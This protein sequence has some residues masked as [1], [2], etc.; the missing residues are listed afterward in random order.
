MHV[1]SCGVGLAR[2]L[3]LVGGLCVVGV[4]PGTSFAKSPATTAQS[5]FA[6]AS[7]PGIHLSLGGVAGSRKCP[8]HYLSAIALIYDYDQTLGDE[9]YAA[10]Y[11]Y[12]II[13]GSTSWMSVSAGTGKMTVNMTQYQSFWASN[14]M[15]CWA[16]D[17]MF[18]ADLIH[19]LWHYE[20]PW[21]QLDYRYDTNDCDDTDLDNEGYCRYQNDYWGRTDLHHNPFDDYWWN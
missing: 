4:L 12:G 13:E 17:N 14:S 18:A 21:T 16:Q 19:E 6:L 8:D 9:L 15:S 11:S 5:E 7:R 10:Y 2:R 20:A 3:T 1:P